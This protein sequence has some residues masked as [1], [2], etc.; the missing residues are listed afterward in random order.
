MNRTGSRLCRY[1]SGALQHVMILDSEERSLVSGSP[2]FLG[3]H[4][5][6]PDLSLDGFCERENPMK[7][8]M[9]DD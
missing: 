7:F 1:P 2:G 8:D 5:G 9:D 3:S 6:I 4:G